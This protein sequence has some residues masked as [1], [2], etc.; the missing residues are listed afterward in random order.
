MEVNNYTN[1]IQTS[2]FAY[3]GFGLVQEDQVVFGETIKTLVDQLL[4]QN[5]DEYDAFNPYVASRN[6]DVILYR[7]FGRDSKY[8][9]VLKEVSKGY[10]D[11]LFMQDKTPAYL[12]AV[13][14]TMKTLFNMKQFVRNN[15]LA[16]IDYLLEGEADCSDSV[17]YLV[18]VIINI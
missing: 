4:R 6:V 5:T 3:A 2:A 8:L 7:L 18:S 17:G 9:R 14:A 12:E 10:F 11:R 15:I 16:K 1:E 13:T